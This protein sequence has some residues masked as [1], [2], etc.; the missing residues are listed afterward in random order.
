[1]K[2]VLT[3]L[4]VT[5]SSVCLMGCSTK[6][7]TL[8]TDNLAGLANPSVHIMIREA[9]VPPVTG[10][11]GWGYSLLKI[12]PDARTSLSQI[13]NRLHTAMGAEL[14]GKGLVFT[15]SDPELLVSYALAAGSDIDAD[16]LNRAYGDMIDTSFLKME[17]QMHY[18]RG[19]LVLDVV[20]RVS[21]TL[22]WRGA[23]MAEIEMNWPEERKQERA[24]D[25]VKALLRHYP[26]PSPV[27]R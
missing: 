2:Y 3:F 22:L 15:E 14:T 11:F 1:M 6:P 19:V 12:T 20:E 23:I 17:T 26:Q 21:G 13:N 25:A 5:M 9:Q 24:N 18:K 4:I 8:S 27:D 10:S 16:E 7:Q